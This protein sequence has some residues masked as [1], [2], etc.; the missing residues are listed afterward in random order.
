MI[1]RFNM[2][3]EQY[4]SMVADKNQTYW[5]QRTPL[6]LTAY[7]SPVHGTTGMTPEKLAFGREI[8]LPGD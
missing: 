8:R 5:D 1:E 4:L 2:T 3:L 6:L 7:K